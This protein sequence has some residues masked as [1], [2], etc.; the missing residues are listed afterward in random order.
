MH[1]PEHYTGEANTEV[2]PTILGMM[3]NY[4]KKFS[5]LRISNVCKLAGVKI[6]QLPSVKFFY[7]ENLQLHTCNMFTLKQFR[8]MLCK[9]AHFLPTDMGKSYMEQ[10]VKMMSTGVVVAV[11]KSEGGKMG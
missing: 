8:N 1:Y 4:N 6:Y 10:L 2:H 11:T 5:K 3:Q 7:G 9:M